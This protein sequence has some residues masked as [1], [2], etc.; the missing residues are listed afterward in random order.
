MQQ[1]LV[2]DVLKSQGVD[3]NTDEAKAFAKDYVTSM[4]ANQATQ[5]A[6]P[7]SGFS[8]A[9]T[10]N[11]LIPVLGVGALLMLSSRRKRR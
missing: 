10:P 6:Q 5:P 1:Q 4:Q 2:L 11:W 8:Q 9:S 7:M 3:P